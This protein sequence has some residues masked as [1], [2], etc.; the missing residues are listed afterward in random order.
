MKVFDRAGDLK[1]DQIIGYVLG[2]DEKWGALFGISSPDGGK[3]INGHFQLYFIEWAR[4]HL[5]G[6]ACTFGKAYLHNESHKSNIFCFVERKA[7]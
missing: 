1:E 2:P 7:N 4:Q 5:E 6:H 3:T